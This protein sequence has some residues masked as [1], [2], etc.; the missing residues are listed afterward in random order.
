MREGTSDLFRSGGA[1]RRP[2]GRCLGVVAL[3]AFVAAACGERGGEGDA[4]AVGGE[5]GDL[6]VTRADARGER[7]RMVVE[8]FNIGAAGPER[9]RR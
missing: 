9:P 5:R 4:A 8:G 3:L 1:L 7:P 6:P 2:R